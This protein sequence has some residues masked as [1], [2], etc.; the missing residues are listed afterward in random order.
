MRQFGRGACLRDGSD[1]IGGPGRR[2]IIGESAIL[3]EPE[4][5]CD[6]SA[7][8][9]YAA[10]CSVL[11]REFFGGSFVEDLLFLASSLANIVLGISHGD[12][13]AQLTA[14]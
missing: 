6:I 7:R 11:L 10:F 5:H 9:L 3:G 13:E 2:L 1:D 14:R 8:L 4:E 12:T